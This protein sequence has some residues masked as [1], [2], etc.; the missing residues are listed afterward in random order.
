MK[1]MLKTLAPLLLV[2]PMFAGA[3]TWKVIHKDN[4]LYAVVQNSSK[5]F[6][7]YTCRKTLCHYILNDGS[8]CTNADGIDALG[9]FKRQTFR[10]YMACLPNKSYMILEPR[11]FQTQVKLMPEIK[12]AYPNNQ[13]DI[14]IYRFSLKGSNEAINRVNQSNRFRT[15][16]TTQ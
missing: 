5:E 2:A 16:S 4:Q 8:A 13:G 12:I 11:K 9:V 14:N 10:L 15:T 1:T 6:F 3:E 7:G